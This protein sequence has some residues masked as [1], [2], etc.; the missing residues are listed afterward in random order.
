MKAWVLHGI[1]DLRYETVEKPTLSNDEVLVAVKA[2]GICGSDIPRIYRTGTYSYPLIPGHEFAGVVVDCGE[3][4]DKSL[5]D[6]RV[7][8]FPLIPCG[9]CR[10]CRNRQYEMCRNYSYLGSRR[11]GGFAEYVAVPAKNLIRLPDNVT[12]EE[13]AMLEPMAV[14]VHAIRHVTFSDTDTIVVCGLGTIGLLVLMFLMEKENGSS[15][16]ILVVGN[17]DFQWRT[18]EQ[19]GLQQERYCD[20]RKQDVH[21]WVME[22]T[23]GKGADVFFEC[24]GKNETL[25]QAVGT[26]APAG[27]IV[28]VGNPSSD[29]TLEKNVYWK[30]LRNQ[31]TVKGTWNSSFAREADDDWHYALDKLSGKRVTPAAL[32]THRFALGDLERGFQIMLNKEEDYC[33]V[34]GVL[35]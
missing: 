34:M 4:V 12:F 19:M 33:K 26:V 29:M 10:P 17:K 1:N 11:D 31:I 21:K 8:V 30:L 32:I 15:Q 28:L 16:R 2:A 25:V 9:E 23:N 24:V 18:V 6:A 20:S 27:R 22:R 13:A 7:G 5:K 3:V 35:E 14:A